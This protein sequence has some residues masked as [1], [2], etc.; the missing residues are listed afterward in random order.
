MARRD[1]VPSWPVGFVAQGL[2]TQTH[3]PGG[4]Q[5]PPGRWVSLRKILHWIFT[6]NHPFW[7]IYCLLPPIIP[8]MINMVK[9]I[10]IFTLDCKSSLAHSKI[11]CCWPF[12][13]KEGQYNQTKPLLVGHNAIISKVL[14]ILFGLNKNHPE[15]GF[16]TVTIC[17]HQLWGW[18]LGLFNIQE[19]RNQ[20]YF[21]LLGQKWMCFRW[22]YLLMPR[23]SPFV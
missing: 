13:H 3:P 9:N 15:S 6:G 16:Q 18:G 2:R 23:N 21:F 22:T 1:S 12:N 14:R 8:I 10:S 4:I 11:S 7:S 5:C 20:K 17:R 19:S